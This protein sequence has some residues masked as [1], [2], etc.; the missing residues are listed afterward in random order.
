MKA[1]FTSS[2]ASLLALWSFL[3]PLKHV[4]PPAP[5]H[6]PSL[7]PFAHSPLSKRDAEVLQWDGGQF[8]RKACIP[9]HL[10]DCPSS[11]EKS[12]CIAARRR[13]SRASSSVY[14]R[15]RLPAASST[16]RRSQ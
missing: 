14:H 9:I 1:A 6:R 16:F 11:H 8:P 4:P 10:N 15:P 7:M 2:E 5:A 13:I 3:R 12:T